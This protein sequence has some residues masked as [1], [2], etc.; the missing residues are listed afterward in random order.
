MERLVGRLD[1][2]DLETVLAV[3]R[4]PEQIRGYGNVKAKAM[5][6]A[7]A[8]WQKLFSGMEMNQ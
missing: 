6:A 7:D 1:V 3:A 8:R 4:V 5:E 2:L